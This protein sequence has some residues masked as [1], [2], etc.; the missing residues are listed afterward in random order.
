MTFVA[1]QVWSTQTR[2]IVFPYS[3]L[4]RCILRSV[5]VASHE[6]L[7]SVFS[8][9]RWKDRSSLHAIGLLRDFPIP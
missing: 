7:G 2:R 5:N 9:H 4:I 8:D 6:I 3:R 1:S